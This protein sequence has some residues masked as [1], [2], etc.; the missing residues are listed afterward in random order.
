M[1]ARRCRLS[2]EAIASETVWNDPGDGATGGGVSR[3]FPLPSYQANASVPANV[4]THA[5]GRGVPDVCGNA[6][7]QTGYQIRVDG[8]DEVVGGTSAV[9]PLWAGLIAR[10]N[11]ELGA[12]LG[13]LQPAAVSAAGQRVVSRHHRGQQRR[14]LRGTGLGRMHRTGVG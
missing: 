14:V 13:F 8:S 12:P 3:Q 1:A 2:G 4:D 5:A 11:Q 9:A 10:L 6:D 7:P